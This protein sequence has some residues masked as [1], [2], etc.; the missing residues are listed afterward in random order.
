MSRKT[1]T[2]DQIVVKLR[3]V[4]VLC[5]QGNSIAVASRQ[6]GITEQTYYRW[7]ENGYCESFNSRMRDEFLNGE[8]LGN[9]YEVEVLTKR[10]VEYYNTIRPHSALGGKPPAPQCYIPGAA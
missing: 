1:Y 9:M 4:E 8:L 5:G 3:E 2:V 10:W 7:W 6:A